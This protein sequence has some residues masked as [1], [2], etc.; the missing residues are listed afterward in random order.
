MTKVTTDVVVPT[1][2]AEVLSW[3]DAGARLTKTE[4]DVIAPAESQ[5]QREPETRPQGRQVS[6]RKAEWNPEGLD[7]SALPQLLQSQFVPEYLKTAPTYLDGEMPGDIG[8]DPWGLVALAKPTLQTDDFARTAKERDAKMLDLTPEQQKK[9]LVWMRESEIKHARLAMIAVLGWAAAE[10]SYVPGIMDVGIKGRAPSLFNGA[11]FEFPS[12]AVFFLAIVGASYFEYKN[13]DKVE[14]LN[15]TGYVPGDYGFD[16][17]GL[18]S[19]KPL[20]GTPVPADVVAK[21][22]NLGDVEALRLAEIKNGRAAMMAITGFAVQEFVWGTPVVQ[23]TPF[24]FGR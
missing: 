1:R 17:L 16:P 9:N 23:Q 12:F 2:G 21:I 6:N 8:F 18:S 19:D 4:P 15:P 24:F 14:G 22:P 5:Q 10:L 11:L 3:Y 7:V 20:A 13:L